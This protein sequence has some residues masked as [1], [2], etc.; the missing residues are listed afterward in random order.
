MKRILI[1]LM[2]ILSA[3]A[4][5][6]QFI[7]LWDGNMPN[8]KGIPVKD[9]VI[10][11]RIRQVGTPGFY[12]FTP[13]KEENKGAAVIICPPGGYA[14]YAYDIAG[15]QLAKWFNTIGINAFVLISRLPHSPDLVDR[16]TGSLQDAQ[17]AM[18]MIRSRAAE[19][20][21]DPGK[22]GAMGCSAGGHLAASM[23]TFTE[24]M[25]CVGDKY[26]AFPIRPDFLILVSPVITM[27][28]K[29]HRGSVQNL[30]GDNPSQELIDR[31]SCEKRVTSATPPAFLVHADNDGSVPSWNSVMFYEALKTNGVTGSLHVFPDGHH[32]IALRNNP[33]STQL[34]PALCEL[35]LREMKI[36]EK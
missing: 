34:W 6:Q 30:L 24:D 23:G 3:Q 28:E 13:S 27:G 2:L 12:V 11:G 29:A 35:W 21:I 1:I 4:Y 33:G 20:G 7:P 19:W 36:I 32:A 14:H 15:F 22:I 17:R 9:S 5:G 18:K 8:S 10:N 31:F 25:A 26:D 16:T